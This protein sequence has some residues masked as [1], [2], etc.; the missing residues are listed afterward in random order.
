M[1][2]YKIKPI[3]TEED[4]E[5]ALER[6]DTLMDA[7]FG[8][9]DFDELGLLADL[10]EHYES[11]HEPMGYPSPVGA[12]EFHMDQANLKPRDLIPLIGSRAKVSEILSGER[13]ITLPIARVL[14]EHLGIPSDVLLNNPRIALNDAIS[15]KE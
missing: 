4:Y 1:A 10:I 5:S 13:E 15:S 14:H 8:T 9:A 12:I 2:N 7:V 6:V 11:K 3:R